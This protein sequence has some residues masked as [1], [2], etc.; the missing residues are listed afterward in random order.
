MAFYCTRGRQDNN[1]TLKRNV[2]TTWIA[3]RCTPAVEWQQFRSSLDEQGVRQELSIAQQD[4]LEVFSRL[5]EYFAVAEG[6]QP[7]TLWCEFCERV[8]DMATLSK[9]NDVTDWMGRFVPWTRNITQVTATI[10][11]RLS[12]TTWTARLSSRRS[13]R[14]EAAFCLDAWTLVAMPGTLCATD[15]PAQGFD[16]KTVL[17]PGLIAR[18]SWLA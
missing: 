17:R 6:L 7:V 2:P 5:L 1:A 15:A 13:T 4:A 12:A 8:L 14:G 3:V 16:C 18:G 11:M 10:P 9:G